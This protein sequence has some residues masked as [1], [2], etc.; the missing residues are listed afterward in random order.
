MRNIAK[1][2]REKFVRKFSNST[3]NR[4][5]IFSFILEV[6]IIGPALP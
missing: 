6:L 5:Q 4:H 1:E 2:R 3:C